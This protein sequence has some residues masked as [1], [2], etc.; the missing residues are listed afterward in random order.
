MA[1]S[2]SSRGGCVLVSVTEFSDSGQNRE[3][4]FQTYDQEALGWSRNFLGSGGVLVCH[5]TT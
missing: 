4:K 1:C 3:G 5:M 2:G